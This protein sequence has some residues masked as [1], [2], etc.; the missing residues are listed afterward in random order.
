VL[1]F[2]SADS[3]DLKFQP[4]PGF[5][6]D[7]KHIYLFV[8]F[9]TLQRDYIVRENEDGGDNGGNGLD[10]DWDAIGDS[11]D[12]IEVQERQRKRMEVVNWILVAKPLLLSHHLLF[13]FCITTLTHSASSTTPYQ[14]FRSNMMRAR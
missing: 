4:H 7:E 8:S 6:P 2:H 14:N 5:N 11:E 13:Q 3:S 1:F 10:G 9:P 12:D